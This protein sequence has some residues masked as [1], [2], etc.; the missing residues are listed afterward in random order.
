MWAHVISSCF[1]S[2]MQLISC[3]QALE[4]QQHAYKEGTLVPSKVYQSKTAALP[5]PDLPS[6]FA[7]GFPT[8]KGP[9]SVADLP[10]I[11]DHSTNSKLTGSDESLDLTSAS[12]PIRR[13]L[14]PKW[15]GQ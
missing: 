1:V 9:I 11:V 15:D 3:M 10:E 13:R 6:D 8:T 12:E 5:L 4:K 14:P 7:G 2:R